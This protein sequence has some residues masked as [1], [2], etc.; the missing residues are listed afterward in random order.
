[1]MK[2]VDELPLDDDANESSGW[3]RLDVHARRVRTLYMEPL[4]IVISP[5]I[6]LRIH[7]MRASP[8]LPGLRKIHIPYTSSKAYLDLSSAL[9]LALGS[10]LNMV[11]LDGNATSDRQ[12]FVPFLSSLYIKSPWIITP[13]S[14]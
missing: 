6:Y 1:M 13:R 14:T 9:F 5:T 12:F 8:L 10:A 11:E 2:F 3:R 4:H 7:A